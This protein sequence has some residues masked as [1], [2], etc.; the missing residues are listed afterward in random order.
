VS[1]SPKLRFRDFAI[2]RGGGGG[3]CDDFF[4]TVCPPQRSQTN[5]TCVGFPTCWVSSSDFAR[6]CLLYRLSNQASAM[7][8]RGHT[9]GRTRVALESPAVPG[10][11]RECLRI[12]PGSRPCCQRGPGK[13]A[14]FWDKPIYDAPGGS[15]LMRGGPCCGSMTIIGVFGVP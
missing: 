10:K 13:Q 12:H 15:Y 4:A 1:I 2:P 14:S 5:N 3:G 7:T 8:W 6:S 11:A 9:R